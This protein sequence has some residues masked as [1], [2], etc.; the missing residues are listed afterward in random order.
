MYVNGNNFNIIPLVYA[1]LFCRLMGC[2]ELSERA[3]ALIMVVILC[4][5]LSE[6]SII[7]SMYI[8][9]HEFAVIYLLPVFLIVKLLSLLIL[10][11]MMSSCSNAQIAVPSALLIVIYLHFSISTF[12]LINTILL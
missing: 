2:Y 12:L 10:I 6:E 7:H 11:L 5:L 9:V 3:E 4:Y 8:N 1:L